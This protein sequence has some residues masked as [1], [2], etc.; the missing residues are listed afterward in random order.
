[1][2]GYLPSPSSNGLHVG[3]FFVHAYGLV[4]VVAVTAAVAI[5]VCR[6]EAVGGRRELVYEVALWGFPAG[7]LGGR[8]YFLA[9][10]WNEV[11]PRWWGPVAVWKGGLGIWGGIAA[12]TFAGLWVLRR[13]GADVAAFLDAAAP[14]LLVAQAIGR[15]GN[16]FNQELFGAPTTLPWALEISPAHRPAGYAQYAT[17]QPT[18]L[19]ELIWNL[20]LAAALVGIGHHRRVRAPGLFALYVAGYSFGRI[21]EELLRVD[22]AQHIFGLRLNLYV[23]SLLCL[24]ALVGFARIQR[25][26][27]TPATIR[28]GGI[29]LATCGALALSGWGDLTEARMSRRRADTPILTAG[30]TLPGFA[31]PPKWHP[32][33]SAPSAGRRV[34]ESGSRTG[35]RCGCQAGGRRALA[36]IPSIGF[37]A[38][39]SCM[40]GLPSDSPRYAPGAIPNMRLKALPKENSV[41]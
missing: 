31:T 17:F 37:G 41:P 36:T 4:Y 13:R 6:W 38:A 34:E 28:R 2:I 29:L 7:L 16:Y 8:L 39:R 3:P 21:G 23:A 40:Q 14:T 12:G 25:V 20:L 10:S 24:G 11:P 22:P 19:Y 9:T 32:G 33:P 35:W 18:F 30:P 1:V 5:T 15:I 26:K 27:L